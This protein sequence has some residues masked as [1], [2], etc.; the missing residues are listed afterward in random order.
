MSGLH[1]GAVWLQLPRS[2]MKGTSF[3]ENGQAGSSYF[4]RKSAQIYYFYFY[5]LKVLLQPLNIVQILSYHPVMSFLLLKD[6]IPFLSNCRNKSPWSLRVFFC[7]I[8]NGTRSLNTKERP[9]PRSVSASWVDC[10]YVQ[11]NEVA[12]QQCQGLSDVT[13]PDSYT[14]R[15][16]WT[17]RI[18]K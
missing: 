2:Q 12:R 15:L 6:A 10:A 18:N 13:W 3:L 11:L 7:D 4:P 14:V 5:Q 16:E 1:D 9:V 17:C 8:L